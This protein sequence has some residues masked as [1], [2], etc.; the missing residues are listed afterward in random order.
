MNVFDEF[1]TIATELEKH[2]VDYALVGGVALAF[3][4]IPRMT[5]DIDLLISEASADQVEAI[6]VALGYFESASPW[7]FRN[8]NITLRRFMKVAG[9]RHLFVDVMIGNDPEHKQIIDRALAAESSQA[10]VKVAAKD[11]LIWLKRQRNSLQDQADIE[12]LLN[13][14]D[15]ASPSGTE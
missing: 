3:H 14:E 10:T 7:P 13:D 5:Q 4:S 1:L 8:T 6:L 15:R 9:T 11:D 12:S 2:R